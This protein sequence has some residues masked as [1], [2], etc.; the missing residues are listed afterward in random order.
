MI[1]P[2]VSFFDDMA[3]GTEKT[4][5]AESL[6]KESQVG[7]T[8]IEIIG[9]TAIVVFLV[10]ATQGL[11]KNYKRYAIE[12]MAVQRLKQLARAENIYRHSNDPTVN[13]EGTY[14]T[15]FE[16]QNAGLIPAIYV[17]SDEKRHTVNAFV[18]HYQLDFVRSEEL[19][20]LE[21]DAYKYLIRAIPLYN[22]LGLKTFY[23]QEDGE[24][25]WKRYELWYL[26]R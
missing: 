22:S 5:R 3:D 24:V 14:G 11:I 23:M 19:D 9:V 20:N 15:F 2:V 13:P 4:R 21:P 12:E 6:K 1:L 25:Y 10:L 18:P 8:L 16:L 17:Q 7:Y 26:P